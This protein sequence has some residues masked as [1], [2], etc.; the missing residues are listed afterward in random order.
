MAIAAINR[1]LFFQAEDGIRDYKVTGVQTCALPIYRPA[2][3]LMG[4]W[5]P[6]GVII[7]GLPYVQ[8]TPLKGTRAPIGRIPDAGGTPMP[9]PGTEGGYSPHFLPNGR[10]FV[11]VR[12]GERGGEL[13]LASLDAGEKP[14]RVGEAGGDP[15]RGGGAPLAGGE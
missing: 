6:G 12:R 9:V 5:G 10:R 13:W 3:N 4:S 15:N 1:L 8:P 7:W 14:R 11:Y 2:V